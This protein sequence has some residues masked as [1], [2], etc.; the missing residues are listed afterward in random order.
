MTSYTDYEKA[1]LQTLWAWAN[2]HHQGEL[3]GGKRAGRPLVLERQFA[4]ANVLV[5]TSKANK[6]RASIHP[7]QRH[8][9]FRS[10]KSSQALA[11]SA[12]GAIRAFDRLDLLQ[13]VNAECGRP[14][15][16]NNNSGWALDFKHQV[17]CPWESGHRPASTYC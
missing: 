2:Q 5:P 14:A 12:F 1:V 4:S 9:R 13:G 15:F 8:R 17:R 10:L 3:D 16:F 7:N 6:I 11:Q